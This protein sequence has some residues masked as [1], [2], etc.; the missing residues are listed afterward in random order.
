MSNDSLAGLTEGY[1]VFL[2]DHYAVE[3]RKYRELAEFGQFPRTMVISCC[4]SRVDPSRIFNARP[5]ELFIVRN[6]ANLVPPFEQHGDYHG[7]SAAIE[8]AVRFLR[9]EQVLVL[10][11]AQCGGITAFLEGPSMKTPPETFIEK[12]I[13]LLWPAYEA[14][15]AG[16]LLHSNGDAQ[17]AMEL[18]GISQSIKN[19]TTFDFVQSAM[20]TRGLKLLG[21]HFDIASG[22]LDILRPGSTCFEP[23]ME[24]RSPWKASPDFR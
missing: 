14:T 21:G 4:D 1:G 20:E 11:H 15:F 9:V 23:L 7:T 3:A 13:S 10:G 16:G 24:P 17:R 6:V 22:N 12:W 5:G 8:F 2:R 19:L 18:A